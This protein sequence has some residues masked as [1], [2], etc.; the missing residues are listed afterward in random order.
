[1]SGQHQDT[2]GD[3][4]G[5]IRE[6]DQEHS[7]AMMQEHFPELG[8][9]PFGGNVV[10]Q[11][12]EM[13]SKLNLVEEHAIGEV[14][15]DRGIFI[16]VTALGV[17]S[18]IGGEEE[19]IVE[20]DIGQNASEG[21]VEHVHEPDG[22]LLSSGLSV[23]FGGVLCGV[24]LGLQPGSKEL[25]AEMLIDK[26]DQSWDSSELEVVNGE[27]GNISE[28]GV[29]VEVVGKVQSVYTPADESV[30]GNLEDFFPTP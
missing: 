13:P 25:K 19:G 8:F 1:V 15:D 3:L 17:T 4:I 6:E 11:G 20:K 27:L 26:E 10:D 28:I 7:N 5:Q 23:F 18:E 22:T 21:I 24:H 29:V 14:G 2:D 16:D 30:E 9:M 12:V